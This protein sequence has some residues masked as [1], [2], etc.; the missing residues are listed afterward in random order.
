MSRLLSEADIVPIKSFPVSFLENPNPAVVLTES[1][2]AAPVGTA[3][4]SK[5]FFQT[6]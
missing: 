1:L 6:T 5:P 4:Y 2:L 3:Q